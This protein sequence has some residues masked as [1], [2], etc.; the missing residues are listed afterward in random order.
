[1]FCIVTD[2]AA[3]CPAIIV[4][5]GGVCATKAAACA[6][7]GLTV[8]VPLLVAVCPSLVTLILPVVA[9]IGT[10]ALSQPPAL[11]RSEIVAVT[12]LNLTTLF[13]IVGLKFVPLIWITSP[14]LPLVGVKLVI[15]GAGWVTVKE[16]RLGAEVMSQL[17]SVIGPVCAPLA[18]GA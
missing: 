2:T 10:T 18:T 9:V 4:L 12:P 3:V 14:G 6:A 1:M 17:V 11:L 15:V 5:G 8:K 13:A 7:S 16:S